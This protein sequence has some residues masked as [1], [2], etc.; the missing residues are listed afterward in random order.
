VNFINHNSQHPNVK[1]R[2]STSPLHRK[3]YL[4]LLS[5]EVLKQGFGLIMEFVSLRDIYPHEEIF[6]DYGAEWERAWQ[7]HVAEWSPVPRAET[8]ITADGTMKIMGILTVDE[9]KTKPYPDN[10]RTACF[11]GDSEDTYYKDADEEDD[12]FKILQLDEWQSRNDECLRWCTIL[13]RRTANDN[14]TLLFDVLIEPQTAHLPEDC[15][16]PSDEKI[17]VNNVPSTK[18]TLVDVEYSRDQHLP[19]AFRHF[20]RLPDDLCPDT[21]KQ[22]RSK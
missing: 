15:I 7:K 6:L 16:L 1:L 13:E 21:W 12:F 17:Y 19:H 2:W 9:Q 5:E 10:V 22:K 11:F 4:D 20:I 14:E 18:V 8:Y 3:D